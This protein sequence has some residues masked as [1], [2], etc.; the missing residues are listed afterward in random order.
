MSREADTASADGELYYDSV[1][2]V[3]LMISARKGGFHS[4][5]DYI[6]CSRPQMENQLKS[7]YSD[8]TL[9]LV[10]CSR[11]PYYSKKS[12]V[13]LFHVSVLPYGFNT[14]TV[15]FIHHRHEDIQFSFTYKGENAVAPWYIDGI[16]QTLKLK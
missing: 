10:N 6:D 1:S 9:T 12:A 5:E 15:F 7:F 13:I 16:M 4:V 3:V 2:K 8:S 14:C 11:S